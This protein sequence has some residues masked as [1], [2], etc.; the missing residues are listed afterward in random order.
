MGD[1]SYHT[2]KE[3]GGKLAERYSGR[4]EVFAVVGY[5]KETVQKGKPL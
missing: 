4:R 3:E 5:G 2:G 1:V